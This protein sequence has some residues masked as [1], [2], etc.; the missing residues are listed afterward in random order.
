MQSFSRKLYSF[1]QLCPWIDE[2]NPDEYKNSSGRIQKSITMPNG[3]TKTKD[4]IYLRSSAVYKP[5]QESL[6]KD[7]PKELINTEKPF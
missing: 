7:V 1:V 6:L 3:E 5:N 2:L 4:M